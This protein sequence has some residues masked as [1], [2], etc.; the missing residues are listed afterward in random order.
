MAFRTYRCGVLVSARWFEVR[1]GSGASKGTALL[2]PSVVGWHSLPSVM[3]SL[4]HV[5]SPEI[6]RIREA[7]GHVLL[8]NRYVVRRGPDE[9]FS[10]STNAESSW[11]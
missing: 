1:S 5:I 11:R 7:C 6:R 9:Q 10:R 8:Q 2:P 4:A 3:S